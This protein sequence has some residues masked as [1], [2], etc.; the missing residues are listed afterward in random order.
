M[1][2]VCD[3]GNCK[4]VDVIFDKFGKKNFLFLLEEENVVLIHQKK[5]KQ[6]VKNGRPVSLLSIFGL[7][8]E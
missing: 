8:L 4:S 1:L 7:I 3:N 5:I 2:K 6:L